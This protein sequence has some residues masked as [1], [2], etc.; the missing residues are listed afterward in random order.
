MAKRKKKNGIIG[1]ILKW[2]GISTAS[3]FLILAVLAKTGVLVSQFKNLVQAELSKTLNREVT[4]KSIEGGIFNSIT[5]NKV[6]IAAKKEIKDGTIIVIDQVTVNYSLKDVIFNRKQVLDTIKNIEIRRPSLLLDSGQDGSWNIIEFLKSLDTAGKEPLPFKG[7]VF[8]YK[9]SVMVED[10]VKKF[11]SSLRD[12]YGELDFSAD[13]G[14]L[15]VDLECKTF[16]SRRTNLFVKGSVGLKDGTPDISVSGSNINL[17]HYANYLKAYAPGLED[18]VFKDGKA[19]ILAKFAEKFTAE[20]VVKEGSLSFAGI[21][22]DLKDFSC[23]IKYEDDTVRLSKLSAFLKNASVSGRASIE[24]LSSD[25]YLNASLFAYRLKLAD[26]DSV[27]ALKPLKLSGMASSISAEIKGRPGSFSLTARGLFADISVAGVPV[28]KA[29]LAVSMEGGLLKIKNCRLEAFDGGH[30]FEGNVDFKKK[31]FNITGSSDKI[32]SYRVFSSLLKFKELKSRVNLKHIIKCGF[33]DFNIATTA[34]FTGL[35]V[36]KTAL[37]AVKASLKFH[38]GNDLRVDLNSESLVA[39]GD[40]IFR[41]EGTDLVSKIRT[42]SLDIKSLSGFF[43]EKAPD[44]SGS[45]T[46]GVIDVNGPMESLIVDA[47]LNV[48]KPSFGKQTANSAKLQLKLLRNKLA[49]KTFAIRHDELGK[50]LAGGSIDMDG[51]NKMSFLV[52]FTDIETSKLPAIKNYF[53]NIKGRISLNA[54]IGGTVK[55]PSFKAVIFPLSNGEPSAVSFGT[56]D[57]VDIAGSIDYDGRTFFFRDIKVDDEISVNGTVSK[58]EVDIKGKAEKANLTTLFDLLR[59]KYK[60]GELAG[61]FSGS[62]DLKGA[63]SALT[64][65]GSLYTENAQ[66]YGTSV[67]QFNLGFTVRDGVFKVSKLN[68]LNEAVQVRNFSGVVSLPENSWSDVSFDLAGN[69]GEANIFGR[70]RVRGVLVPKTDNIYGNVSAAELY[71]RQGGSQEKLAN[72][73][74]GLELNKNGKELVFAVERWENIKSR[75]VI[76]LASGT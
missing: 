17:P 73:E 46:S 12:I 10:K 61:I 45:I 23:D 14:R 69:S 53:E 25:P 37:G 59:I 6:T 3:L 19:D 22:E 4:I 49:I 62:A 13:G 9:G 28:D 48:D 54:E 35:Y 15:T 47:D 71:F 33:S 38:S 76:N 34:D 29:D 21:T 65:Y 30:K 70:F 51:E 66:I 5:L 8:V 20:A 16:K 27:T 7:R 55:N 31:L 24:K 72:M 2:A 75:T 67:G 52:N 50:I 40:F 68:F 57:P 26:L 36:K 43:V 42:K 18:G 11:N 64:G 44:I 56:N 63:H 60:P 32:E 74:A 39:G 58:S 41:A 1:K